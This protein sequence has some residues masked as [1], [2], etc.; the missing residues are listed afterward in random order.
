MY[1]SEKPIKPI[2]KWAGGKR[3]LLP[4]LLEFM[5]IDYQTYYEPFIGGAA[6]LLATLPSTAIVN[7][8]N[9]ELINV[10]KVIRTN[11]EQLILSLKEHENTSEY[12]YILREKDRD[13]RIW[14]RMTD[15]ERASRTIYLNKTCYNGLFRVNSNG[16]FN[17][18]FGKYKNP[19]ICQEEDLLAL[20]AYLNQN[21][22]T[23][24]CG[25]YKIALETAKEGD[26]AYLDPPYDP[27]SKTA[28]YTAYT[29]SGFTRQNQIELSETCKELDSKG[30]KFMLSNSATEFIKELYKEFNIEIVSAKRSINSN[31]K[32]RGNVNEVIVRNY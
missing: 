28:F 20:S 13:K 30:V 15:V 6:L 1:G 24:L 27:V 29:A 31:G 11:V 10:Y 4:K 2:L 32:G 18:P 25:D 9:E 14:Q 26:F 22:I 12:F 8:Y 21:N 16:K 17:T 5:P 19:T 7:D 23:L 3:Q